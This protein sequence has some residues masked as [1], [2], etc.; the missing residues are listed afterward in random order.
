MAGG[1]LGLSRTAT[2]LKPLASGRIGQGATPIP[3]KTIHVNAY[4]SLSGLRI[5][6]ELAHFV[7]WGL[8]NHKFT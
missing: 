1:G 2:A 4:N 5:Y 8:L 6:Y 7:C 3:P